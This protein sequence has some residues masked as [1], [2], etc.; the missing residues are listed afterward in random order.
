MLKSC[1]H[2]TGVC[3]GGGTAAGCRIPDVFCMGCWPLANLLSC[4]SRKAHNRCC[5]GQP[6]SPPQVVIW[7]IKKTK[8]PRLLLLWPLSGRGESWQ[9]REETGGGLSGSSAASLCLVFHELLAIRGTDAQTKA[10]HPCLAKAR[11][12]APSHYSDHSQGPLTDTPVSEWKLL[13]PGLREMLCEL[14]VHLMKHGVVHRV[15]MLSISHQFFHSSP[16]LVSCWAE[17]CSVWQDGWSFMELL[18]APTFLCCYCLAKAE[19]LFW[20]KTDFKSLA[21]FSCYARQGRIPRQR[22]EYL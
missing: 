6:L 18:L 5:Q 20:S 10:R 14:G 19:A 11:L 17:I 2:G 16:S 1:S 9:V 15:C 12:G 7:I 22:V 4:R 3:P 13:S 8:G 21:G